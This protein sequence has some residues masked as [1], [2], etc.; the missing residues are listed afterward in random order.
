MG[1]TPWGRPI[2]LKAVSQGIM[3]LSIPMDSVYKQT[4][5]NKRNKFVYVW[6]LTKR[7]W[8]CTRKI[9][10]VHKRIGTYTVREAHDRLRNSRE[11]EFG[12]IGSIMV[13]RCK[14]DEKF[15]KMIFESILKCKVD[16][17]K[18]LKRI[19]I[20]KLEKFTFKRCFEKC[21]ERRFRLD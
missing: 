3:L 15:W 17:S 9:K 18:V 13:K 19:G 6:I 16:L 8:I 7:F 10:Y 2:G 20:R 1:L 21:S 11:N 4:D 5:E 14:F 12:F